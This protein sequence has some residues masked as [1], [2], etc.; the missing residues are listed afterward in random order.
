MDTAESDHS[1][2]E[3]EGTDDDWVESEKRRVRKRNSRTGGRTSVAPNQLD[4]NDSES[5]KSGGSGDGIVAETSNTASDVCCSCSR[6]SSCKT[7]KCKCLAAGGSCGMSCGC[8]PTKCTNRGS[9]LNKEMDE[10]PESESVEGN[11]SGSGSEETEKS[12]ILASHGAMLLQSALVEKLAAGTDD[13]N[14][15]KRK[16]LSDIGNKLVCPIPR[17]SLISLQ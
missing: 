2:S 11:G 9:V 12:R 15:P 7:T 14:A 8:V 13:E 4:P 3:F 16:P 17:V 10:S 6:Y 5:L 1:D